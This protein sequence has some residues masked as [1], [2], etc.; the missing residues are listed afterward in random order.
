MITASTK[1]YTLPSGIDSP[2]DPIPGISGSG[3]MVYSAR[4]EDFRHQRGACGTPGGSSLPDQGGRKSALIGFLMAS[5]RKS[6]TSL[7]PHACMSF[8]ARQSVAQ[9]WNP[10]SRISERRVIVAIRNPR[11]RGWSATCRTLINRFDD[12]IAQELSDF[13]NINDVVIPRRDAQMS[14]S[15]NRPLSDPFPFY[16]P[17]RS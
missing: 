14:K 17:N 2:S 13:F 9:I 4:R 11:P 8:T 16:I 10:S 15:K 1:F 6:V 3:R 5:A 12:L 7:I